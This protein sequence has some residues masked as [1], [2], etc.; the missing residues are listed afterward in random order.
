MELIKSSEKILI[1]IYYQMSSS[2]IET[3]QITPSIL[4]SNHNYVRDQKFNNVNF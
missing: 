4:R 1:K 3:D 2:S